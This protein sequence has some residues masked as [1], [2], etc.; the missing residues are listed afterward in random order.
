[1]PTIRHASELLIPCAISRTK[2][3]CFS[4]CTPPVGVRR[5][6]RRSPI[7][8]SKSCRCCDAHWNPPHRSHPSRS[9]STVTS[10]QPGAFKIVRAE[11]RDMAKTLSELEEAVNRASAARPRAE[12]LNA[13]AVARL[14]S[15]DGDRFDALAE[16]VSTL[17]EAL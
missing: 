8:T 14:Q 17:R 13:L 7:T 16:M 4:A 10:Y 11:I 9:Q 2:R 1:M 6:T 15:R 12:A 5:L 3:C